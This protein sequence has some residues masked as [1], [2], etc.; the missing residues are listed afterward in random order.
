MAYDSIAL[1]DQQ[2]I[3]RRIGR[4]VEPGDEVLMRGRLIGS[5]QQSVNQPV[6]ARIGY[7]NAGSASCSAFS[8]SARRA[9]STSRFFI[10]TA[11]FC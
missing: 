10:S 1:L 2:P 4:F 7:D 5:P 11:S 3:A 9:S 6:I 8:S